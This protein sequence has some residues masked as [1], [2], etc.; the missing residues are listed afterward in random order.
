MWGKGLKKGLTVYTKDMAD[1]DRDQMIENAN[2]EKQMIL[3][4]FDNEDYEEE[5]EARRE[6]AEEFDIGNLTEDYEAGGD[7]G[8]AMAEDE[9]YPDYE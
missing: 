2:T 1:E 8:G 5:N 4:G 7:Y 9:D 3:K 6:E